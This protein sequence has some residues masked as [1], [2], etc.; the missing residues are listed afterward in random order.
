MEARIAS[1]SAEE[2]E[3]R[4]SRLEP[5]TQAV[6]Q[7]LEA[8][9]DPEIPVL[10]IEDLGIL[11]AVHI[12][13]GTVVVVIT[14]TYSG[15]PAMRTIEQDVST[16][17]AD[18]GWTSVRIE[19]RLSPAWTTRWMSSDARERLRSYGIAAPLPG[20]DPRPACPQCGAAETAVISEFG[21]TSCKALH[22]CTACGEP[23]DYFK[24]I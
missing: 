20:D 6:W 21:S 3:D 19:T 10:S 17:L 12:V 15:C 16:T 14:P 1:I 4:Q 9:K 13:D 23:F 8:V 18:A 24:Q 7:L 11:R 5:S 2:Y 22:R